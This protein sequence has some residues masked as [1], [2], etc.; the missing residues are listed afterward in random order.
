MTRSQIANRKSKITIAG[1]GPGGSSLAIRLAKLGFEVTLLERERFPRPKLC[2]EFISPECLE[3]FDELGVLD[4]MLAAGGDQITET[5]FFESGGKSVSVPSSWFGRGEFALSLSRAEMDHLLLERA[6]QLGVSVYEATS[7]TGVESDADRIVG[8]QSRTSDGEVRDFG[9]DLFVDATGRSRVIAKL[10]GRKLEAGAPHVKPDLIG[11][12]T[13]LE[14]ASLEKGLCEIYSFRGGYAGLSR[15]ENDRFN[16]CFLIKAAAVRSVGSDADQIVRNVIRTNQRAAVTLRDVAQHH[17]WLAVSIDGFGARRP[18][19]ARNLFSVGDAASFIDPFTGSGM[20]MAFQSAAVLADS[21][22][23]HADAPE[24]ISPAYLGV[25]RQT[26][27]SRHRI[28]WVLRQT[29]FMPRVA[30]GI[31]SVLSLSSSARRRL[32]RSTRG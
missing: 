26:F 30:T 4:E 20:S 13:H 8:L 5:R 31:V 23:A 32:A 19:P 3:H 15:V 12:K 27:A 17:D 6:R 29:A 24:R 28:C 7:I 1:A 14:T 2:G 18:S 11:F 16:L 10:A 21:I 9:G 22:A 25:Y